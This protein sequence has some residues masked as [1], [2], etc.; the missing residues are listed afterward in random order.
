MTS[1]PS[2][3]SASSTNVELD[4]PGLK[5]LSKSHRRVRDFVDQYTLKSGKRINLL[6]D[7]R[8]VNLSAAE[9]HP[10]CVMDMS[11]ANQAGVA[12]YVLKNHHKL[13]KRVY[14]VPPKL[15][16]N[17]SRLKLKAMGVKID[18]LTPEQEKYLASWH[19]GT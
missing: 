3:S 19:L 4:I 2:S 17:I 11:F 7:G 9:G 10:A 1:G 14:P 8:L 18:R 15:D 16:S 13:E 6:A 12:E 5:R